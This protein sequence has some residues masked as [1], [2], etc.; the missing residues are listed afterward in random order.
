MTDLPEIHR[1]DPAR[2]KLKEMTE[3]ERLLGR[4]IVPEM[5]SGDLGIDTMQALLWVTLRRDHPDLTFD[6][7]GEYDL[8]QLTSALTIQDIEDDLAELGV[9]VDP[10]RA[11]PNGEP[12]R[13]APTDAAASST[14]PRSTGTGG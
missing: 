10:T 4:R 7:I 2:I 9:A 8:G 3:I 6:D 13:P 5:Q 14:T 12:T 1:V 11:T